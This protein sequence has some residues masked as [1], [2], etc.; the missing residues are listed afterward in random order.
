MML[1]TQISR[2]L[3]RSPHT[4]IFIQIPTLRHASTKTLN[5]N[6][7]ILCKNRDLEAALAEFNNFN[8]QKMKPNAITFTHI[9]SLFSKLNQVDQVK[10]WFHDMQPK[11]NITPDIVHKNILLEAYCRSE[12]LLEA[13]RYFDTIKNKD[14]I[15]FNTMINGYVTLVDKTR[16]ESHMQKA[17]ELLQTMIE[18]G[19]QLNDYTFNS[20]ITGYARLHDE[21]NAEKI[22]EMMKTYEEPT[23][24][25]QG[26]LLTAYCNCNNWDA[27]FKL[28]EEIPKKN[29][30]IYS[31]MVDALFR[32]GKIRRGE[33][34]FKDM[35]KARIKPNI[36]VIGGMVHGYLE[37]NMANEAY[38]LVQKMERRYFITPNVQ[39]IDSMLTYMCRNNI[40]KGIAMFN[41][42]KIKQTQSYNIVIDSLVALHRYDDAMAYVDRMMNEGVTL[43]AGTFNPFISEYLND[44]K[45][46]KALELFD[47]MQSKFNVSADVWT[48]NILLKFI[49]KQ[50]QL[51]DAVGFFDGMT[52]R[53]TESYNILITA[54]IERSQQHRIPQFVERMRKEGVNMNL[55]TNELLKN[56]NNKK[57]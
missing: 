55:V 11:Y 33:Q 3:F 56:M 5:D 35:L 25:S 32:N 40:G 24:V 34:L 26:A 2:S 28:F 9:L 16:D 14:I 42:M 47:T 1:L 7:K 23:I 54:C 10:H 21:K 31:E 29:L 45:A 8:T 41:D 57:T 13:R 38:D 27:A 17:R 20:M 51:N 30:V 4:S 48:E 50:E 18:S 53:N 52:S 6:I 15:T 44:G 43:N 36:K 12:N 49:V 19:L 46:E 39:V 37:N 22:F